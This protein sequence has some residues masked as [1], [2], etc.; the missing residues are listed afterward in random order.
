MS[1]AGRENKTTACQAE[2]ISDLVLPS[3]YSSGATVFIFVKITNYTAT[4]IRRV[5]QLA[6]VKL[7]FS[8]FEWLKV[9]GRSLSLELQ[10]KDI[11]DLVFPSMHKSGASIYFQLIIKP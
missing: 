2:A 7:F 5:N 3:K 10:S 1:D 8:S 4:L 11:S 6:V 9:R